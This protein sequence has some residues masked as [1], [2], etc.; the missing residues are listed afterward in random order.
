MSEFE[1]RLESICVGGRSR[2]EGLEKEEVEGE[3]EG[4]AGEG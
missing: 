1:L 4:G 3:R 2:E